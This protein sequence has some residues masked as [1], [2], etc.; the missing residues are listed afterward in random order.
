MALGPHRRL[1]VLEQARQ[2]FVERHEAHVARAVEPLVD[3][4]M[5]RMRACVSSSASLAALSREGVG[6]QAHQRGHQ[7]QAVGDAMVDLGQQHLGAVARLGEVG[8]AARHALLEAG[9]ERA[10]FVAGLGDFAGVAAAR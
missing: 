9:V 7:R 3:S 6:L 4:E 8:G 10:H 2:V 5:A 1:E